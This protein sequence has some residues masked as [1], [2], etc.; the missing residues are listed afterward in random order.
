[1]SE[2]A[3]NTKAAIESEFGGEVP[4]GWNWENGRV[5][6]VSVVF[7]KPPEGEIDLVYFKQRITALVKVNFR[8]DV[9]QVEVSL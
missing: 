7:A 8:R 3:D 1:M 5:T 4:I 2:D 9:K 6:S